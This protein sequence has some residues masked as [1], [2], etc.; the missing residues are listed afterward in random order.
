MDTTMS[1]RPYNMENR[2]AARSETRLRILEA[3]RR[4]LADESKI[5]L[6]MEA[7]ARDADVS[8]LTIYYQFSSRAGLLEALFDHLAERGHMRRMAEVFQESDPARALEKMVRTF[9][10][11]WASDPVALR[12][13]R[14]MSALDPEIARGIRSRDA[15]R[16]HIA[17]EILK[18]AA[19]Q[20]KP[21]TA[22]LRVAADALGMLTSFESYDALASAGQTEEEIVSTLTRLAHSAAGQLLAPGMSRVRAARRSPN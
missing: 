14:A 11:F 22:A 8:R 20:A 12:R 19:A 1:P 7:V 4:L 16:P 18:R 3:A 15:R 13:L 10:G 5:D 6:S 2:Q 9:V 21:A 17:R